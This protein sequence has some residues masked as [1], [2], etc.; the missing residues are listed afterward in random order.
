M[1]SKLLWRTGQKI[2]IGFLLP[3]PT[4]SLYHKDSLFS[5]P[6]SHFSIC[7]VAVGCTQLLHTLWLSCSLS[8][9]V[10][11]VF[12]ERD[13]HILR[14]GF[15]VKIS[16]FIEKTIFSNNRL[17]LVPL[18]LDS[19]GSLRQNNMN[20]YIVIFTPYLYKSI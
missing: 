1:M 19:Q 13:W 4:H 20:H 3:H 5:H 7:T 18:Q 6:L 14:K 2:L 12:Y 10:C 17:E 8:F 9:K 16:I 15:L 11:N